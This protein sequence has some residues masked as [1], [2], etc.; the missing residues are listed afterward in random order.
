MSAVGNL[1]TEM[2]ASYISVEQ[3]AVK[4]TIYLLDIGIEKHSNHSYA[5]ADV[6]QMQAKR[7]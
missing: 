4:W 6:A 3:V 2:I 7:Y 1:R 5:S